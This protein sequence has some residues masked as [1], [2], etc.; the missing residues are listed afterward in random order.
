MNTL[1]CKLGQLSNDLPAL[2]K[3]CN[4]LHGLHNADNEI[5]TTQVAAA[6]YLDDQNELNISSNVGNGIRCQIFDDSDCSDSTTVDAESL[7][8][9]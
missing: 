2:A 4:Y 1:I 3:N 9:K 5:L 8:T 6:T 7:G